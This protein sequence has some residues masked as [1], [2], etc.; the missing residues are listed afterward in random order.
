MLR[1]P[2]AGKLI[3]I[4][5]QMTKNGGGLAAVEWDAGVRNR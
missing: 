2:E 5:S 1:R 4:I 3:R